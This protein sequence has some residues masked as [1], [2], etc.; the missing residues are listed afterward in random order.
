MRIKEK[1]YNFFGLI[2]G[3][4]TIGRTTLAFTPESASLD[5]DDLFLIRSIVVNVFIAVKKKID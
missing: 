3:L 5:E 2:T 4:V 1:S